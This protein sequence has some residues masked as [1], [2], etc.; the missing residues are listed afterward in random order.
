[1]WTVE[2]RVVLSA[3]DAA[4]MVFARERDILIHPGGAR[5]APLVPDKP[6]ADFGGLR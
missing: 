4:P 2:G 1:M 3:A 6:V 5:F